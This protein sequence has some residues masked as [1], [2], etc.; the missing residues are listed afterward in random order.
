MRAFSP[1]TLAERWDVSP[2]HIRNMI[3]S[4][5][6]DAFRLGKLYRIPVEEVERFECQTMNS[7][8]TEESEQSNGLDQ[9]ESETGARLA[10]L[11]VAKPN[12]SL[13]K[14]TKP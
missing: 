5:E 9:T 4:K 10:R 14:S 6:L 7:V 13:V 2:A 1:R 11:T 8:G 3:A 12:M